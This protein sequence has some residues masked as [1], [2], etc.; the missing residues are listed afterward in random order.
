ML[1]F[2]YFNNQKLFLWVPQNAQKICIIHHQ[3]GE[4]RT[5]F[6]CPSRGKHR[7]ATRWSFPTEA[8][9]LLGQSQ[10]MMHILT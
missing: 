1:V 6:K 8:G 5:E 3:R 10:A 9:D 2:F 7:D 4:T